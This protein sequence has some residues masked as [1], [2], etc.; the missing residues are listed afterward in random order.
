MNTLSKLTVSLLAGQDMERESAHDVAV[1]LASP[2]IPIGDKT[3]F[4]AALTG[5]GETA[6]EVA[7]IAAAFRELARNPGL[8]DFAPRAIDIVGTG[9]SK[10]G[11]YNISSVSAMIV[12]ASGTP[13]IKHGNRAIT[14]K[15]GAADFLGTLGVPLTPSLD[16]IKRCLSELNFCFLF[17]PNFH[18]A[19][20]EIGP[21]RRALAEKGQRT[22]FNILGPLINPAKPS[23]E[24]L[25]VF[26]REWTGPLAAALGE[27][28]LKSGL[29]VHGRLNESTGMDEFSSA[30]KNYLKG[31]GS[32]A[33]V[34]C[35]WTPSELGLEPCPAVELCGRSPEENVAELRRLAAGQGIKGLEDTI[36]LN[37]GAAFWILGQAADIR[38]GTRMARQV[39]VGGTLA[40]WLA[41]AESIFKTLA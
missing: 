28:G 17:A 4:L 33:S 1:E 14:S 22:V 16:S 35:E 38:E 13:V 36:S 30:G 21:A 7:S 12:A 15:S 37:A 31:F 29:T 5:K 11:S 3:A 6:V 40:A 34:D 24:L 32:M 25:G 23:F 2:E 27:L 41:K 19:F 9:G 18:P 20:K 39:L 10:S 8:D 26:A